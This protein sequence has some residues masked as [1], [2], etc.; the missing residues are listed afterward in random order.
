MSL[1]KQFP[2]TVVRYTKFGKLVA[3][4]VVFQKG[5]VYFWKR[6]RKSG[7]RGGCRFTAHRS[8]VQAEKGREETP[9]LSELY[10]FVLIMRI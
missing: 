7:R 5:I 2:S 9:T 1:L 6:L 10:N 3:E 4:R 8:A